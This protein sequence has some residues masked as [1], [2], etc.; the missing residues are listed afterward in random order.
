[1]YYQKY[2]K[3]MGNI[4]YNRRFS[5]IYNISSISLNIPEFTGFQ[6]LSKENTS[7]NISEA[8]QKFTDYIKNISYRDDV[9]NSQYFI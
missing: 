7:S 8:L 9:V 3:K 5:K 2:P 1:M 6:N 4:S